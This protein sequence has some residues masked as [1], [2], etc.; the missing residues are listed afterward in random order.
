MPHA[1]SILALTAAVILLLAWVRALRRRL[2]LR[3]NELAA[4]TRTIPDLI[5]TFDRSGTYLAIQTADPALLLVPA[6]Q[7]L[8][9]R[10]EAVLPPEIARPLVL[11]TLRSAADMGLAKAGEPLGEMLER[12]ATP[13]GDVP[14]GV[15][16]AAGALA[17]FPQSGLV[18]AFHGQF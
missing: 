10:V 4:L 5:I 2:R 17:A 12:L 7:L 9:R 18:A 14:Y 3:S 11:E 8:N 1:V 6:G 13:G 16:I 15:A